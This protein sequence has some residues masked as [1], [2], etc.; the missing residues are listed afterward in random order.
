MS[1]F[2]FWTNM[3][4]S[5]DRPSPPNDLVK[6]SNLGN[7][8]DIYVFNSA[9]AQSHWLLFT[10]HILACT[11]NHLTVQDVYSTDFHGFSWI[12]SWIYRLFFVKLWNCPNL[13]PDIPI[14]SAV[15]FAQHPV[16]SHPCSMWTVASALVISWGSFWCSFIIC[17]GGLSIFW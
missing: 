15:S 8:T 7:F 4:T 13:L 9:M 1:L 10:V 12:W 16:H 5:M 17:P 2:T 6:L 11:W 14:A 3:P